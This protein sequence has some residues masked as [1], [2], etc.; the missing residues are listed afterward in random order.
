MHKEGES[1]WEFIQCFY[2]KRNMIPEVDDKSII[3]FIK[4]GLK[5]LVLIR[6]LAM[7]NPR[8]SEEMLA[9]ANKYTLAEEATLDTRE[10]KKNKKMSHTD[11]LGTSKFKDK[12]R[13]H[14]RSVANVEWPLQNQIK[15]LPWLGE[16]EGFLDG[17]CIFH[18][19]GKHKTQ[20]RNKLQGFTDK[21]LQSTK[22]TEQE[23]KMEDL[24]SDFLEA[25]K[26]INYIFDGTQSYESKRKRKLTT[27]EVM[28]IIPVTPGYLKWREV[29]I[30]FDRSNHPDFIL[31]SSWYHLIVS[32]IIKDFKLNRVLVDGEVP[33]TSFSWRHSIICA[34]LGQRCGRAGLLFME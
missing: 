13:K 26:E 15:Y 29:P 23:K 22:K 31:K 9:I 33:S 32:P 17:I 10:S 19:Q 24:K 11:W 6:K 16:Y 34:Y 25:C 30:A 20:D 27:Q 1:L 18:P 7:K 14:N 12:K 4:K 8:T 2:N 21:V 5:D 3:M 28:A